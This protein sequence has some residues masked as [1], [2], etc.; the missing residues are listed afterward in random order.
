M[1]LLDEY[2]SS[3]H[4]DETGEFA[5]AARAA[6]SEML[7]RNFQAILFCERQQHSQRI[8]TKFYTMSYMSDEAINFYNGFVTGAIFIYEEVKKRTTV[9]SSAGPK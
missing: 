9:S 7:K 8:S 5:T 4:A 3:F 6:T 2:I 1:E